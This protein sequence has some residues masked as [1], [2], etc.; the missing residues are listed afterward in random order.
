MLAPDSHSGASRGGA[1]EAY[2]HPQGQPLCH[3]GALT[4]VASVALSSS[5][6]SSAAKT[7]G[8]YPFFF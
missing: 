1:A 7:L 4:A 6:G 3:R 5:P 2:G 8:S